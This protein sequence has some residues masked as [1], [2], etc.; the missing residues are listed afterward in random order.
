MEPED[1]FRRRERQPP[2]S[3]L[4]SRNGLEL[5]WVTD[6]LRE[7]QVS[8][9]FPDKSPR[10]RFDTKEAREGLVKARRPESA[11]ASRGTVDDAFESGIRTE[12]CQLRSVAQFGHI[13]IPVP[14]SVRQA[15]QR[16]VC[17]S[18]CRVHTG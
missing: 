6:V 9:S 18:H 13:C 8:V 12:R 16:V 11:A 7:N 15:F 1:P 14:D 17:F 4:A 3:H 10:P 2:I 5:S